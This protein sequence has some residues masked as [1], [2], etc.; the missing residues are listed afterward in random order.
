MKKDSYITELKQAK[1]SLY[2]SE[3]RYQIL[4]DN[5][6]D[7]IQSVGLDG[8]F[9][10]VNQSWRHKL[11]YNKEE[12]FGLNLFD[13][14]HPDFHQHCHILFEKILNGN[15]VQHIEVTFLAK[16][17]K[18][19]YL[20]GSAAP[21]FL[22]GK[23]IAAQSFFHDI[24]EHKRAE[25][26]IKMLS[27]IV[28]QSTEGMAIAGLDGNLLYTNEAWGRMHGY[29][30]SK[31]LLGKNLAIFHNKEQIENEVKPFN[32]KVLE[33]GTCSGEVGHITRDGKPFPT[34]MTSTLLKDKQGQPYAIAGIAKDITER[35]Q[36]EEEIKSLSLFP[37]E[38]NDPVM[39]V[40][41]EGKVVY[42]N[43][44]SAKCLQF[45]HR[46]VGQRI[47]KPLLGTVQTAI[48][49]GEA[50]TIEF[51]CCEDQVLLFN[52]VPVQEQD[53]VNI[54]GT[55]ITKLK[56]SEEQIQNNLKEKE[57]LLR[58]LYHRTKNNM[59][60]ISSMLN[61]KARYTK[62][63]VV[64]ATFKEI[65]NKISSM[66]L[67]HQKLYESKDLSHLN[68][69]EY[70]NDLILLFK[71][72]QPDLSGRITFITAGKDINVLIDTAIPVGLIINELI[73]NA[74][75]H[76]FLDNR[77]GEIK[78]NFLQKNKTELIIELSDN[79]V[80]LPKGFD[81]QKDSHLGLELVTD[82]VEHQLQGKI[83]YK[84]KKGLSWRI[85]LKEEMY[86]PRV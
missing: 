68:L 27:T 86:E 3:A 13:V 64:T 50:K 58:E 47:F 72:S 66:A 37:E 56:H 42:A 1:Q 12:I 45:Y 16:E 38:N 9:L 46:G 2:E 10:F 78:V 5:S 7:L 29:K 32:E 75:K 65:G 24:T 80:G 53:Y 59:Q 57:I 85:L 73:N 34:L 35:K 70:I 63:K 11:G 22:D 4:I 49:S 77:Q 28:E 48:S 15:K 23:V 30:S 21:R 74:L 39:R 79:G 52:V 17:G 18:S 20:V 54:Y 51:P 82:L 25:E 43:K 6:N 69:K 40:S 19:I 84:S 26:E 83:D 81:L 36:A 44:A 76:A 33:L 60:V 31:E 62:N 8:R 71:R 61:L 67:V 41:K 14:I 55:D